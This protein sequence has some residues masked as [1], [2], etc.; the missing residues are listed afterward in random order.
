MDI[1]PYMKITPRT[2]PPPAGRNLCEY[3]DEESE[4]DG[5][6]VYIEWVMRRFYVRDLVMFKAQ[7]EHEA[8]PRQ[9][10]TLFLCFEDLSRNETRKATVQ[11]AINWLYPGGQRNSIK[12]PP[13]RKAYNS[14][15]ATD[16]DPVIRERLLR[17]V[18]TLDLEVFDNIFGRFNEFMGNCGQN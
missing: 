15:H 4:E 13:Q 16:H 14:S 2:Y 18:E 5:M 17:I 11:K 3:L 8:D 12:L 10:R 9:R 7:Q 6:R 1:E